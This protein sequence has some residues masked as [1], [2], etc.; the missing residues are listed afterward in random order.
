LCLFFQAVAA[1][2]VWLAPRSLLAWAEN[3]EGQA[4]HGLHSEL[5]DATVTQGIQF[6]GPQQAEDGSFSPQTGVGTTALAVL[7]LLRNG[8]DADDRLVAKGLAH[9]EGAAWPDGSICEPSGRSANYETCLALLCFQAANRD[10]RYNGLLRRGGAFLRGAQRGES[11]Q[12]KSPSDVTF[13]GVGYHVR[14][15]PDLPNTACLIDALHACGA[16]PDDQAIQQALVF[17]SRCQNLESPFNTTPFSG[18]I[19]D[20]GF[21]Y[22]PALGRQEEFRETPEEG[23]LSYGSTTCSGLTSMIYAG[24][25]QEDPRVQAA[26][27]WIRAQSDVK[28]NPG[29]GDAGL[30]SYYHTIAKALHAFGIDTIEDATGVKHD[31]RRELT[32]ELTH[33]QQANG[34]WVNVNRRWREGDPNLA[35][36]FALLALSYCRP[37][38]TYPAKT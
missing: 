33:R 19:N 8:R 23:L 5:L 34:S 14:S 25:G 20:G 10:G 38:K 30:Y 2:I 28:N 27:A 37:R 3:T 9:L 13:G 29:M 4:A 15:A 21:Y 22:T 32:E 36:A 31:W 7:A 6:L 17:V 24:L 18:K 12:G 11:A 16:G 26:L 35:T 1:P